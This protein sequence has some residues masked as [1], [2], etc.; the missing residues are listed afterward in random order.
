MQTCLTQTYHRLSCG[1]PA[2]GQFFVNLNGKNS[3]FNTLWF[4]FCTFLELFEITKFLRFESQSKKIKLVSFLL[5]YRSSP[6]HVKNLEFG[7]Y[8]L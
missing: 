2:V 1:G 4:I 7:G 5:T 6:N 3:Y 8:I